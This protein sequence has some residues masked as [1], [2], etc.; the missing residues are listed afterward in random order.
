MMGL[1]ENLRGAWVIART[2]M[3]EA[4]RN[5]LLL[6]TLMFILGLT[7]LSVAVAAVSMW[8]RHRLII[9]V[10]LAA[11]SGLGSVIALALAVS[12][13]AGELSRRTVYP[14][15]VRPLSR[16]AF[17][18]GKYLGVAMTM[19]LMVAI[20]VLATAAMV[21]L[22]GESLPAAFWLSLWLIWIEMTMVCAVAVLFS[23][24]T[25]PVLAAAY[26]AA[27]IIAGNLADDV[28]H[29]AQRAGEDAPWLGALLR[30]AYYVLPD[31]QGISLRSQ[32]AN[33]IDVPLS[34]VGTSTLYGIA[35]ASVTI[36]VGMLVFSRRRAF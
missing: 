36:C 26:T 21:W 24:L 29:L 2:T 8:E 14:V 11:A 27:V 18:L 19:E 22:F 9:D 28:L 23:T 10:G 31:L 3:L 34:F 30:A 20:M 33:A 12:S 35:Y 13:F 25:G 4:L 7:A 5:R 32:A 15:L 17:V 1:V 16:G 6:I